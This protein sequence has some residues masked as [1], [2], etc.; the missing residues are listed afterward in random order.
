VLPSQMRAWH[1]TQSI[2]KLLAARPFIEPRLLDGL[3][4]HF[5]SHTES[6]AA[7]AL[8]EVICGVDGVHRVSSN[9]QD[10]GPQT[11]NDCKADINHSNSSESQAQQQSAR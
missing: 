8:P 11:R 5:Q 3:P 10:H 9:I 4:V 2:N 6:P 1:V 7:A